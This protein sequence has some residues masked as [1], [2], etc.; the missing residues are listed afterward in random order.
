MNTTDG[1]KMSEYLAWKS[2]QERICISRLWMWWEEQVLKF[3]RVKLVYAIV[4]LEEDNHVNLILWSFSRET[5]LAMMKKKSILR[6][7]SGTPIYINHDITQ[8]RA[9]LLNS[10]EEK[11]DVKAANMINEKITVY[12]TKID[13]IVFHTMHE[14][15]KWDQGLVMRVWADKLNIQ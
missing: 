8:L 10:L 7:Q 6:H 11:P 4:S 3:V 2:K 5:K 14:L 13:K 15:Y 9:R 12:Q 1:D